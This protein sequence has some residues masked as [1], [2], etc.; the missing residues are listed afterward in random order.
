MGCAC[1]FGEVIERQEAGVRGVHAGADG[2]SYKDGS[3]SGADIFTWDVCTKVVV[4]ASGIGYGARAA[5]EVLNKVV[6]GGHAIRIE[7]NVAQFD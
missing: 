6:L 7:I 3:G 5:M 1:R 4:G 2:L